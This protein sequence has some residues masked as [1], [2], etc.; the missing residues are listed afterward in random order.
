MKDHGMNSI[1]IVNF[2]THNNKAISL[3]IQVMLIEFLLILGIMSLIK[4]YFMAPFYMV[5]GLTLLV[6]S[7]NNYKFFHK[8]RMSFWYIMF[9]ALVIVSSLG[10]Y[11]SILWQM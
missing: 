9:G 3:L 8:K 10:Q 2:K 1:S 6:M 7:Y 5:M 11:W 4:N